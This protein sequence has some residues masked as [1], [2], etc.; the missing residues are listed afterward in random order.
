MATYTLK[1]RRSDGGRITAHQAT[2]C[3]VGTYLPVLAD[4]KTAASTSETTFEV[5]VDCIVEDMTTDQTAGAVRLWANSQPT[6]MVIPTDASFAV[7]VAKRPWKPF[8]LRKGVRYR[9]EQIEAGAA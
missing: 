8:K 7:S 4:G 3:A 1:F 2:S 9:L 5:P 6:A